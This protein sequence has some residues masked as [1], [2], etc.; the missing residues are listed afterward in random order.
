M[1]AYYWTFSK[2]GDVVTGMRY[3]LHTDD[4]TCFQGTVRN[5]EVLNA[6]SIYTIIGPPSRDQITQ[7]LKMDFSNLYYV[8]K[9]SK[10][11]T[12]TI[13]K[14]KHKILSNVPQK[15]LSLVS[16]NYKEISPDL[17][18][19]TYVQFGSLE[20]IKGEEGFY[21]LRHTNNK[22]CVGIDRKVNKLATAHC[23]YDNFNMWNLIPILS[24]N[25]DKFLYVINLRGSRYCLSRDSS[26]TSCNNLGLLMA[27]SLN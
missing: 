11:L 19:P 18:I 26:L 6:T 25:G 16:S 13:D 23:G 21:I 17:E 5:D 22:R 12:E 27:P 14:C 1:G 20:F 10:Y 24:E 3:M 2:A 8:E 15:Q 7:N 4:E 9:P